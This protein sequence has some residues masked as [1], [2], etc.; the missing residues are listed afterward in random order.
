MSDTKPKAPREWWIVKLENEFRAFDSL[1]GAQ[2]VLNAINGGDPFGDTTQ[3]ELIKVLPELPESRSGDEPPQCQNYEVECET[4]GRLCE[5][6]GLDCSGCYDKEDLTRLIKME[7]DRKDEAAREETRVL[8]EALGL[9][10]D[11][12]N[13]PEH[14]QEDDWYEKRKQVS[15]ALAQANPKGKSDE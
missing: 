10:D 6:L 13:I 8:R 3:A 14:A 2:M 11:L 9:A 12:L 7:F 1:E 4:L 15:Q 5:D